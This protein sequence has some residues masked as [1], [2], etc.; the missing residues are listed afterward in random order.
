MKKSLSILLT[1]LILV[2]AFTIPAFAADNSGASTGGD[3]NP[4]GENCS[5][6][7]SELTGTLTISGTGAMYDYDGL[8]E[9]DLPE[10]FI[11]SQQIEKIV[12][13]DGITSIGAYAFYML[14]KVTEVQIADSVTSIGESAFWQCSSLTEI[15]LPGNL[16]RLGDCAFYQCSSLVNINMA[17]GTSDYLSIN[18]NLYCRDIVNPQKKALVQYAP[19]KTAASFTIPSD[20]TELKEGAFSSNAY[21]KSITIPNTVKYIGYYVFESCSALTTVKLNDNIKIIPAGTFYDCISLKTVTFGKNLTEISYNAFEGCLALKSIT[22]PDSVKKIMNS[23]FY[24]CKALSSVILPTS[25]ET[26]GDFAFEN[27][28]M[29]SVY[30]TKNVKEIGKY[31]FGYTYDYNTNT[32]SV[33]SGFKINCVKGTKADTAAKNYKTACGVP[34]VYVTVAAKSLN[35]GATAAIKP[36]SGTAKAWVSNKKSVAAVKNGKVYALKKGTATVTVTIRDG[37]KVTGKVTVKTSPKLSKSSVTVKK[38]K[39]TTVKITGK[40]SV[41]AN[42]YTNTKIAKIT[43][44]NTATTL[45]VKGLKKGSTT[46][47]VKVNGVIL[48]LKVKVN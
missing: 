20:V 29:K 5:W 33:K 14:D 21:L 43:S 16:N 44:K 13:E 27:T 2:S 10:W 39:T 25:L 36:S 45:T 35:A 3:G 46:L 22:I 41:I 38:G 18:G 40:C 34:Y 24:R 8:S 48:S 7:W 17:S 37:A 19:G 32:D 30:L 11:H 42:V 15:T 31:A 9:E 12:V 4:A 23:A 1:A 26:V 28:A 47:K 6:S